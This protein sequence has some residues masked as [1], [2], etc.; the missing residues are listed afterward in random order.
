MPV[1]SGARTWKQRVKKGKRWQGNRRAGVAHS[2]GDLSEMGRRK[3]CEVKSGECNVL[4]ERSMNQE[5][6]EA[7]VEK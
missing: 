5:P 2:L 4:N 7:E 1:E 3:R 6:M